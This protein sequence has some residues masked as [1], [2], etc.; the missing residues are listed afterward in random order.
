MARIRAIARDK[1]RLEVEQACCQAVPHV[2]ADECP[3]IPA[4][5]AAAVELDTSC[6]I[7]EQEEQQHGRSERTSRR[8]AEELP[9]DATWG[10][11]IE[12]VYVQQVIDA[13]LEASKEG[14]L[15][16]VEEV[17]KSSGLP[18]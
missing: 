11:V 3:A 2:L 7:V 4:R 16:T 9:D 6:R 1:T 5:E 12:R 18:E 17:R 10:D 14:Q 13:G 15:R 8:I